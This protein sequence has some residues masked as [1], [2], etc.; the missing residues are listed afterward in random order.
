MY[1]VRWGKLHGRGEYD[2]GLDV[3][4]DFRQTMRKRVYISGK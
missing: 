4:V 1:W 3:V 2:L